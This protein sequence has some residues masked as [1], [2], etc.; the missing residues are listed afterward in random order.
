MWLKRKWGFEESF[1][2][3]FGEFFE[4]EGRGTRSRIGGA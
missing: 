4:E 3:L 1:C 2:A